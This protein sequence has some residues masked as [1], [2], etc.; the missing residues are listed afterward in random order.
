[1]AARGAQ[2]ALAGVRT[3]RAYAGEDIEVK[4]YVQKYSCVVY[5][6]L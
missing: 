4:R 3:V 5:R 6:Q 2:E 1:M